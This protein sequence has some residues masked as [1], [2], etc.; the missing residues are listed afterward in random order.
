[1][2][3]PGKVKILRYKLPKKVEVVLQ[4]EAE[5]LDQEHLETIGHHAR[6]DMEDQ[7]VTP[8]LYLLLSRP[9]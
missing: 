5:A 1:M 8:K 6:E 4:E 9:L 7:E 3:L 2:N